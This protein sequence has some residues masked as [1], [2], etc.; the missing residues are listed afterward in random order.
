M[1]CHILAL[2]ALLA[3]ASACQK[4]TP[5]TEQAPESSAA[6]SKATAGDSDQ[7]ATNPGAEQTPVARPSLPPAPDDVGAP[8]EDAQK[9][10]SGVSYRILEPG[11]DGAEV[12]GA[13]DLVTLHYDSWTSDGT[14]VD[15]TR[16]RKHP[17]R[18]MLGTV[19][20]RGFADG[21]TGMKVG[22][23]RRLWVPP[24]KAFQHS[25]RAP[26]QTFVYDVEVQGVEHAPATPKDVARPPAGARKTP[27]GVS[28]R[29][30]K[31]GHG[32]R[33]RE[34]DRVKVHLS[35]WTP[36]GRM[37][38]STYLRPGE[39][40]EFQTKHNLEGVADALLH[41]KPG[42]KLRAWIPQKLAFKGVPNK[43]AGT[44]VYDLELLDVTRMPDPPPA[45]KNVSGPPKDAKKT[46]SG[47][48]YEVLKKGTGTE[49]PDLSSKVTMHYTGWTTDG[50]RFD[51]SIPRGK[52]LTFKL[53]SSVMP[54]WRDGLQ[55][56]V[57]GQKN[58]FWIPKKLA[59]DGKPN[60][61]QGMLVFDIELLEIQ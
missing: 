23:K 11:E 1:R 16:R 21:V 37:F 54:G 8:P 12:V 58:R 42:E 25:P 24:D 9:T 45:P 39:P 19:P 5:K 49:H 26:K 48:F 47:V 59:Y 22:E 44:V 34:W 56:M 30:L 2:L 4:G 31:Q 51:S 35:A 46:D 53:D 41:M 18:L 17:M 7:P 15:S 3:P 32:Q 20:M 55:T 38:Y 6:S 61:P 33:P 10:E 13:N 27:R 57:V 36:E 14:G 28:Y 40:A 50:E 60:R 52:P 29:V 43:P